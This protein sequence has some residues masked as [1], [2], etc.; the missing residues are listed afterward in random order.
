VTP[1]YASWFNAVHVS[2]VQEK[3]SLEAFCSAGVSLIYYFLKRK[4]ESNLSFNNLL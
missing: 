3:P 4:Y 2:K 1:K